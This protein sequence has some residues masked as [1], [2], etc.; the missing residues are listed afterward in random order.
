MC[1]K[2]AFPALSNIKYI[3]LPFLQL[4]KLSL[5]EVKRFDQ[6]YATIKCHNWNI[7]PGLSDLKESSR[8]Y[9]TIMCPQYANTLCPCYL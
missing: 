4:R 3:A 5:R 9:W 8:N 7:S 6:S 1:W 2:C